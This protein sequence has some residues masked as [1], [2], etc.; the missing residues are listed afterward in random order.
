M[1]IIIIIVMT[2]MPSFNPDRDTSPSD[3]PGDGPEGGT[4]ATGWS[5]WVVDS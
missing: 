5:G 2:K 4:G 3:N 1:T